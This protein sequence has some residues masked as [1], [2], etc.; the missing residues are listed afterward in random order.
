[1]L[2]NFKNGSSCDGIIVGLTGGSMRV[3]VAGCEDISEFT[4][5][6]GQWISLDRCEIVSFEFP[7]ELTQHERF[8]AAVT[9]AIKP[10]ARLPVYLEADHWAP[11]KVN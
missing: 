10:I 1:V 6:N 3:A 4:L 11:R 8:K 9:E 2:I 7:P 5:A